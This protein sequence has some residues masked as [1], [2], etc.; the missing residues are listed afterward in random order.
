MPSKKQRSKE[1][2]YRRHG[3]ERPESP[4]R[5]ERLAEIEAEE[6]SGKGKSKGKAKPK[7]KSRSSATR[8]RKPVPYPTIRRALIRAPIFGALW[9]VLI[10]FV[11]GGQS[12]PT[13]NIVQAL[14]LTL[15]MMPLLFGT[16][17]MT[18]RMA[19]KR[20]LETQERPADGFLG[21]RR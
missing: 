15:I 21:F 8:A 9:Y 1:E 6:E 19:K 16:D 13:A 4:Q 3:V 17:T 2:R 11:L 20:G 14:I 7:S 10:T 18:Y 12:S 5:Q